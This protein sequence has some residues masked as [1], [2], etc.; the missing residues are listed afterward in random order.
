M[1]MDDRTRAEGHTMFETLIGWSPNMHDKLSIHENVVDYKV[2][3]SEIDKL[4]N[5]EECMK[6]WS[7]RKRSRHWELMQAVLRGRSNGN[8]NQYAFSLAYKRMEWYYSARI[9]KNY[10][11]YTRFMLLPLTIC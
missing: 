11:I 7:K 1:Q 6:L 3:E 4:Q 9:S 10:F 5:P 2:F 8:T